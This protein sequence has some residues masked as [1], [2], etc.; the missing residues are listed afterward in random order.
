MIG[1]EYLQ[2]PAAHVRLH[3]EFKLVDCV[4]L[5]EAKG[6]DPCWLLGAS[7]DGGELCSQTYVHILV[8]RSTKENLGAN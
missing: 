1:E 7:G 2:K 8:W 3:S 5:Q 6:G 4:Y